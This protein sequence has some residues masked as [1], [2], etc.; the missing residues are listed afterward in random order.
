MVETFRLSFKHATVVS[1]LNRKPSSW[2]YI[3]LQLPAYFSIRL[4]SKIST[5]ASPLLFSPELSLIPP[6]VK[7]FNDLHIAKCDDQ[8]ATLI[9]LYQAVASD[10]VDHSSSLEH[11]PHLASGTSLLILT[12][13]LISFVDSSLSSW[14]LSFEV[15]LFMLFSLHTP[16]HSDLIQSC[17]FNYHLHTED[18]PKFVSPHN[19]LSLPQVQRLQHLH[20]DAQKALLVKYGSSQPL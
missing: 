10:T 3:L 7:V 11:F 16:S 12:H 2:P 6:Q 20:S 18:S 17:D 5:S 14:S 4:Y 9:L 19:P 15:L 13:C 1:P 8:I